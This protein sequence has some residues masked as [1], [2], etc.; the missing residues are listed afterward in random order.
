MT[1][2]SYQK[3][4]FLKLV[5][6]MAQLRA[7]NGCPWDKEQDYDSLKRYLI[8]ESYEVL[9]AI[10][11]KNMPHLCEELGDVLLQVVFY[12]E[13]ASEEGHF[14]MGDV[15]SAINE[16]M[17]RRHPH[18]FGEAQ[19]K[20]SQEVLATWE[21]IKQ[22]EGSAGKKKLMEMNENLPALLLAQK[23]QEKAAR[24][25]FDWPEVKGAYDKLT[26]ELQELQQAQ[27]TEEKAEE[28]GDLFFTL[29][30]VARLE[31]MDSEMLLRQ[32]V[33]KFIGRFNAVE[34]AVEEQHKLW[35]DYD[36]AELE[37]FWQKAKTAQKNEIK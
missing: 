16:K 18:V 32:A 4:Q 17:I 8:E 27:T 35:A 7:E 10:E 1:S 31:H 6:I 22:Q 13:L 24:I 3:E 20:N 28:L 26:E 12:A 34:R 9:A 19:A 23:A 33:K 21:L 30:N 14:D 36:L 15:V 37:Q 2:G 25:G 5:E 11:E 29:V